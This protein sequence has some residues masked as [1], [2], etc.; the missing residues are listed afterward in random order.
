MRNK[1]EQRKKRVPLLYVGICFAL[2]FVSP[3]HFVFSQS[4]GPLI[5][6]TE[7]GYP[8]YSF[9][10]QENNPDGFNVELSR[11]LGE[12]L[13]RE[14]EIRIDPWADIKNA[15]ATG[16]I[17]LIAG[18]YYSPQRD[19]DFDFSPPYG[20]VQ[21]TAFVREGEPRITDVSQLQVLDGQKVTFKDFL[22]YI[23]LLAVPVGII[24]IAILFWIWTLRR[25]VADRTRI[26]E[27]E[28]AQRSNAE[29]RLNHLN[30]V[31]VAVRN[32]NNLITCERDRDTLLQK[33]CDFLTKRSGYYHAWIILLDKTGTRV[34]ESFSSGGEEELVQCIS[35]L[36]EQ[37]VPQ[38]IAETIE[39]DDPVVLAD[40][41][42]SYYADRGAMNI[43]LAHNST[44]YGVLSVAVPKHYVNDEEE[45]ELLRELAGD[46][47]FALHDIELQT[48]LE[49]V[50]LIVEQSPII[51]FRWRAVEG[52]PVEYVSDNV[53]RFGYTVDDFLSGRIH[54]ASIIHPE[55]RK[56]VGAEVREYTE[57][58]R[59]R[60]LQDYRL[61]DG[62]GNVHWV[63]DQTII[64]RDETGSPVAY[65]GIVIDRTERY[66]T[67]K[68][69]RFQSALLNQIQDMITATDLDGK[70]TYVNEAETRIMGKKRDE[71]IGA[72]VSGYGEDTSRGASQQEIIDKTRELGE[73]RGFVVNFDSEGREV[74]LDV[75]TRLLRD[76]QENPIGMVGISTDITELR[77]IEKELIQNEARLRAIFNSAQDVI[78]LKDRGGRYTHVNQA[79][80]QFFEMKAG[81]IIGKTDEELF[82][83][84]QV[85]EIIDIDR[86]IFSGRPHRGEFT[87]YIKGAEK[88]V[89]TIKTPVWDEDGTINGL[90]GVTRDMTEH[91]RMRQQIE[92]A[93][94]EKEVLLRE[95]YHRTKNN[96]QVI[97]SIISLRK[98][99]EKN[100][101]LKEVLNEL[102]NKI[103]SMALVHQKL[104]QSQ[105]LSK[106]DVK[107]YIQ[108]LANLILNSFNQGEQALK[109]NYD[110][111]PVHCLIDTL[112]PLG[113]VI[114]E[115]LTNA[116][117]H[118]F[119]G[120][121]QG[122]IYIAAENSDNGEL[123]VEI[124]DDGVGMPE[125]LEPARTDS[126][127]LQIVKN[128]VELQLNGRVELE[129]VGGTTWRLY[130]DT[131]SY[132]ERV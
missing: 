18:M 33:S 87:R 96:M 80:E 128:V 86:Q 123:V 119:V 89:E 115:L 48:S 16:E 76:E 2:L 114:N 41:A 107:E 6:G 122:N 39:Q 77:R 127:G 23:A 24:L 43:R 4:D 15:L 10:N 63:D 52:W 37:N 21:H 57:K 28:I 55:D 12:I 11:A 27:T 83:R 36:Q 104:Y 25:K 46:I 8:P 116:I 29:K 30:S 56:R 72:Y 14:V 20:V 44:V 13:G 58:G 124:S 50:G 22:L 101:R 35:S 131:G 32:I 60:F 1:S 81:Q 120:R 65:Q 103:Y 108:D 7:L 95:L 5:I 94:E 31:L 9:I 132:Y 62:Q 66:E 88:I 82:P 40:P 91:H 47:G 112:V 26:L 74:L 49:R 105:D 93:L 51:L 67:E 34:S 118:A 38:W 129:R 79:M 3:G 121:S 73:W 92:T 100:E 42:S 130:I 126:I 68:E 75:R 97:A 45:Q 110:L 98:S 106:I 17:N 19:K 125:D 111:K 54:F 117:K 85:E 113:I 69:L 102:E 78:Y 109:I 64:E 90:C 70:I 61:I 59:D 84:E 53:V 71:L 99:V